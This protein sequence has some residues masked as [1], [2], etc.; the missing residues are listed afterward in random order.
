MDKRIP[1][2]KCEDISGSIVKTCEVVCCS[3]NNHNSCHALAVT[4]GDGIHPKCDTFVQEGSDG[5]RETSTR[6]GACKVASCFHNKK[7]ICQTGFIDIVFKDMHSYCKKFQP[8]YLL[9]V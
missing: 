9:G 7:L 6:V 1:Q 4:I 3:F 2:V 5:G 8:K